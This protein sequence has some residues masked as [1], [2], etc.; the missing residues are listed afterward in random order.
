MREP[1]GSQLVK[2]FKRSPFP[3]VAGAHGFIHILDSVRDLR[4]KRSGVTQRMGQNTP[5]ITSAFVRMLDQGTKSVAPCRDALQVGRCAWMI[6]T[7]FQINRFFYP[8]AAFCIQSIKT[9]F[10][11][12]TGKTGFDHLIDEWRGLVNVSV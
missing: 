5:G 7:C 6:L 12:A 4:Y 9:T 11:L 8:L 2:E 3:R 10:A 1:S